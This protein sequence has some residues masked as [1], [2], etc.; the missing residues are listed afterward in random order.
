MVLQTVEELTES[1]W[2]TSQLYDYDFFL[3]LENVKL[4]IPFLMK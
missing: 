3:S 2:K 4:K 1:Y